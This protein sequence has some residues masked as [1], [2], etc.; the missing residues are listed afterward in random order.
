MIDKKEF[1]IAVI[2]STVKQQ[3]GRAGDEA[4]L[5][6]DMIGGHIQDT[7]RKKAGLSWNMPQAAVDFQ[8]SIIEK[9]HDRSGDKND[10]QGLGGASAEPQ[11]SGQEGQGG[12][13]SDLLG[14]IF[15]HI[16]REYED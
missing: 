15:E 6:I 13:I 8:N 12:D 2:G 5:L 11:Q 1:E 9:G 14:D 10:G 7:R 16:K 4:K 3:I